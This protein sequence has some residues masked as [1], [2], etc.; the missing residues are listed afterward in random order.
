M[1][2]LGNAAAPQLLP[3]LAPAPRGLAR[4]FLL[5]M[6]LLVPTLSAV[7]FWPDPNMGPTLLALRF[8]SG[9]VLIA[10]VVFIALSGISLRHEFL[11]LP[12]TVRWAAAVWLLFVAASCF[13]IQNIALGI[14]KTAGWIIHSWFALSLIACLRKHGGSGDAV[15]AFVGG[16]LVCVVPVALFFALFDGEPFWRWRDLVPGFLNVRHF[17]FYMSVAAILSFFAA[18]STSSEIRDG[19]ATESNIAWLCVAVIC[20]AAVMWSG[21]R[22][23]LLSIVVA[24]SA[25]VLFVP[26]MRSWR[27]AAIFAGVL[28][29]A[30]ALSQLHV[31]PD[32]DFSIFRFSQVEGMDGLNGLDEY[33]SGRLE[34]WLET[35]RAIGG[36]P[37]IGHGSG[38]AVSYLATLNKDYGQPHNGTLQ[39]LFEWG[40]I[41]GLAGLFLLARPFWTLLSTRTLITP[42]QAGAA[43]GGITILVNGHLD[44]ALY[45]PWPLVIYILCMT[46]AV[47]PGGEMDSTKAS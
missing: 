43:A 30:L 41:G 29:V 25:V 4:T 20:A 6:L 16:A 1:R 13:N 36:K 46:I 42:L 11:R 39:F 26:A 35:T 14:V 8:N 24:F 28:T 44:A 2:S 23:G 37:L 22:A 27:V 17:G 15:K 33:S 32:K 7:M 19:K 21:S 3:D 10:E 5:A 18:W 45:H 34:M 47:I 9:P 38:Q 12:K 40:V 31:I